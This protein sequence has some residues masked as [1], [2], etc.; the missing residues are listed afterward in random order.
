MVIP[1]ENEASWCQV[2][3]NIGCTPM[4][5]IQNQVIWAPLG[6]LESRPLNFILLLCLLLDILLGMV[7]CVF[8]GSLVPL[9]LQLF[10]FFFFYEK[11]SF[12]EKNERTKG[13]QKTD[14]VKGVKL[15]KK[16][17]IKQD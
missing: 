14:P 15:K 8:G 7:I 13:I 17:S 2:I 5:G 11:P 3:A 1:L 12:R 9:Q 10:N 4:V 16:A 6:I